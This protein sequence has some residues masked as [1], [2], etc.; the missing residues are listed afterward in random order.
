MESYEPFVD[1]SLAN[2][3]SKY[4]AGTCEIDAIRAAGSLLSILVASGACLAAASNLSFKFSAWSLVPLYLLSLVFLPLSIS[5]L[6]PFLFGSAFY[7]RVSFFDVDDLFAAIVYM[8]SAF[9][10]RFPVF[11]VHTSSHLDLL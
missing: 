8:L 2:S 10:I 3:T 11:L 1:C 5:W 9:Y 6:V 4:I 7:A